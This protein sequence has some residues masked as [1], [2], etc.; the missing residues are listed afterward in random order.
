MIIRREE[1]KDYPIVFTLL[2]AAFRDEMHSDHKEQFLVERL[3]K[4]QAFVNELSIVA[5]QDGEIVGYI[6]LTEIDIQQNEELTPSLALAPV[7]VLPTHQYKGIGGQLI[8]YAH[9]KARS[10]GYQSVVVLGHETYYPKFGYQPAENFGIRFPFDVPA[11]NCMVLELVPGSLKN[12]KG[13]V[14]YSPAFFE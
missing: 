2:E 3:R 12:V 6:L 5:E 11:E 10:L 14:R 4:S 1:P 8:E 13:L 9:N 7:A